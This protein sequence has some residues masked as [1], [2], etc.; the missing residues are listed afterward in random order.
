MTLE[1]K[2]GVSCSSFTVQISA[3]SAIFPNRDRDIQEINTH[4]T[5][6]MCEFDIKM[7]PENVS[8]LPGLSR[9]SAS[10]RPGEA[11]NGGNGNGSEATRRVR[12]GQLCVEDVPTMVLCKPKILPLKSVTLEKL[13]KMQ[14]EAQ[15]AIRRQEAVQS[16][17]PPG[18]E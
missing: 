17:P 8:A 5:N 11:G 16:D 12:A 18:P 15:E 7:I 10:V 3:N 14:R 1:M 4:L 9:N 13:E 6:G 2:D